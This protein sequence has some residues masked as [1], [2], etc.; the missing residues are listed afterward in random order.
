MDHA[1]ERKTGSA[2]VRQV[3]SS[4][5]TEYVLPGLAALLGLAV[6]ALLLFALVLRTSQLRGLRARRRARP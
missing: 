3:L 5:L 6:L 2:P 1:V 4:L